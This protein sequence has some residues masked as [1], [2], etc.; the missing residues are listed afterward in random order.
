[1]TI[2]FY[3]CGCWIIETK[4]RPSYTTELMLMKFL[5]RLGLPHLRSRHREII[6]SHLCVKHEL[7]QNEKAIKEWE[8]RMSKQ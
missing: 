3:E 2:T 5:N 6:D 1:M 4:Q 7:E 8:E